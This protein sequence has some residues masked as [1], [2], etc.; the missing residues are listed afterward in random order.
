MLGS[1]LFLV[2]ENILVLQ[3]LVLTFKLGISDVIAPQQQQQGSKNKE[4]ML[5][6]VSVLQNDND[7]LKKLD[8]N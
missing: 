6:E 2:N 5:H 4:D 1:K 7:F 8:Q 3:F